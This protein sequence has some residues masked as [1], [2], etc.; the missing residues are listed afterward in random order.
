M[1]LGAEEESWTVWLSRE[2]VWE[3]YRTLG[4]VAVLEGEELAVSLILN[5]LLSRGFFFGEV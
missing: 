1:P 5:R 2:G 3:R 4:Q